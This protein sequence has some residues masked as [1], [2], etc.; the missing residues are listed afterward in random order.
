MSKTE[1]RLCS[2][3]GNPLLSEHN[4]CPNCG[5]TYT[6]EPETRLQRK[7]SNLS[8]NEATLVI[9]LARTTTRKKKKE[10]D[11]IPSRIIE[12]SDVWKNSESLNFPGT[13]FSINVVSSKNMFQYEIKNLGNKFLGFVECENTSQ[14]L[15]M[16]VRDA[17][18]LVIGRAEGNPQ[19]TRYT[20]KDR[21]NK[22]VGT[23]QQQ[24]VLKQNYVIEDLENN[25]TLKTKG[26]P[27]KKEYTLVKNG[28][29]YV[30][31]LKTSHETY[32]MEIKNKID[33][34]IPILSSILIDATQRK[35]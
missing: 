24:G 12:E 15:V 20:I 34:R 4:R 21:Y 8:G 32:K 14:G 3:C 9:P 5:K 6:S 28:K 33:N 26:D 17:K 35:K 31:I 2:N 25:Q 30:T 10:T 23:I 13:G 19:N 11:F 7:E 22:K 29:N 16:Q 1:V 18:G 27:T